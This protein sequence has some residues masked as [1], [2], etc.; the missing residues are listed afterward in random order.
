[1]AD[2]L[3]P[4]FTRDRLYEQVANLVE[5]LVD[6]GKLQV[7]DRLP[8]ER[9]LA[10]RLGVARGVVR[11]AVKVLAVKGLVTVEPGRGTFVADLN[12]D[13][14]SEHIDRLFRTGKLRHGD[15]NEFR[16]HLEIEV[17]GLAA[18]RAAPDNLAEMEQAIQFMD[19]NIDEPEAY[20][21]ADLA[22]HLALAKAT[23]NRMFPL[24]VEV[25]V[26]ILQESRRMIFR[27]PGAAE[28]GQAWHRL[29]LESVTRGDAATSRE[30][31][32][33]HMAQVAEDAAAGDRVS[34]SR[35]SASMSGSESR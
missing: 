21:A 16:T 3:Y 26:D 2:D 5:D 17:A 19:T 31:M 24:L 6:T 28:R 23:Q 8:P 33:M 12:A 35:P 18:Q 1:M 25:I 11:E 9:E 29:I 15:L 13:S 7:G 22:F 34:P 32:R 27:V 30:S 20:I 4:K 10:E 14:V